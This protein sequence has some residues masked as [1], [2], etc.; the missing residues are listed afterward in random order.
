MIFGKNITL[1]PIVSSDMAKIFLWNDS[2]DDARLNETYRP[3]NWDHLENFWLNAEGDLSRVFFAIRAIPNP[4]IVGFVQIRDIQLVHHSA[5]IGLKIGD[6]ENRSRGMGR[7]ALRL[8]IEYCW[9]HLNLSR[10]TI[11]VFAHNDK[12]IGLYTSLGFVHEGTMQR[13]Q[14]IDGEWVDLTIMALL[15]S[16][17]NNV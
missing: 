9:R 6:V 13:A 3:A 2:V 7:E 1:G 11:N 16:D 10:L 14:F 4:E 12:A 8:A 15:R 17:R 5:I